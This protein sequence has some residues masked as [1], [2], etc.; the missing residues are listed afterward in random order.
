MKKELVN[1]L[2]KVYYFVQAAS[3]ALKYCNASRN[4]RGVFAFTALGGHMQPVHQPT[5][6]EEREIMR[7]LQER[8]ERATPQ[9]KS[10][11]WLS[12]YWRRLAS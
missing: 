12:A 8:R 1:P 9:H 2:R 4:L 3:F 10:P 6:Q 7:E 11:D 5:K